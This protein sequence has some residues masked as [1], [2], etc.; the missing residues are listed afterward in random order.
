MVPR[1]RLLPV[2]LLATVLPL[3]GCGGGGSEDSSAI[4]FTEP[5]S[6]LDVGPR[7][8]DSPVAVLL[9]AR[10]EPLFKKKGCHVCHAYG[11]RLT[12]PDLKGVT[13]RR[14]ARWLEKQMLHPD[15]MTNED[16]LTRELFAEYN[17]QM[18]NQGLLPDEARC[19]IEHLKKLD[20]EAELRGE[21]TAQK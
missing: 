9:A 4:T 16:P 2:L 14:T 6:P 15:I 3:V 21:L 17:L 19:I 18:A 12:G 11:A 1:A 13:R 7:A 20:E 10:G 8:G 5:R